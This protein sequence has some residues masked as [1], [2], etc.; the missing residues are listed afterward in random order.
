[1]RNPKSISE[2]LKGSKRVSQLATR[3]AVRAKVLEQV[4]AALPPALA[5]A[6]LSA[7]IENGQLNIGVAGAAWASRIRYLSQTAR[8]RLEERTGIGPGQI[9]VRVVPPQ[10]I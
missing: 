3:S 10:N 9:R 6:V 7:G 2:L 1:M 8:R 5:A 4:R